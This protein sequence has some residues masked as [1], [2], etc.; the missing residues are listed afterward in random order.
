MSIGKQKG[1]A[2]V[3]V[4]NPFPIGMPTST[5]NRSSRVDDDNGEDMLD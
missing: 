2:H 3:I 1:G 4:K 5:T